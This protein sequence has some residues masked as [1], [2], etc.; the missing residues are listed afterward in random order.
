MP[1]QAV[2]DGSPLTPMALEH[3]PIPWI[4]RG[5]G[6]ETF[7]IGSVFP[8]DNLGRN[9]KTVWVKIF[10][11]GQLLDNNNIDLIS[12]ELQFGAV[13]IVY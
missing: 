1:D 10:G 2:E 9:L 4:S 6:T 13:I 11:T 12:F 3:L 5:I 7:G 8:P